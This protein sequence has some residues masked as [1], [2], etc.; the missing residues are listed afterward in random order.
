MD[1]KIF[2][3]VLS[4][5]YGDKSTVAHISKRGSGAS[6]SFTQYHDQTYNQPSSVRQFGNRDRHLNI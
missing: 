2:L 3:P 5:V 6:R 1:L 4:P